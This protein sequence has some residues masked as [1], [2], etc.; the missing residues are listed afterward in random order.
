VHVHGSERVVTDPAW[1]LRQVTALTEVMEQGR[2]DAWSVGDGP[3]P[4]IEKMVDSIT[5]LVVSIEQIEGKA[6]VSQNR[7]EPDRRAVQEKL[8]GV[9]PK[10]GIAEYMDRS[11]SR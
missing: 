7:S 5:G 1:K 6:K 4:F 3:D 8:G 11:W 2:P 10:V 9:Q